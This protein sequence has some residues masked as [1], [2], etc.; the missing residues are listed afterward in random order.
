MSGAI[1]AVSKAYAVSTS[2]ASSSV[3]K[4]ESIEVIDGHINLINDEKKGARDSP[5][6]V[7]NLDYDQG[8]EG[9]VVQD[10]H[11]LRIIEASTVPA[12]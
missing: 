1:L 12:K 5:T 8:V 9:D 7:A 11:M 2:K 6:S 3:S 10:D 4:P